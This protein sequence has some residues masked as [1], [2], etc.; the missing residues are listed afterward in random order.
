MGVPACGVNA[1]EALTSLACAAGG[2]EMGWGT[3]ETEVRGLSSRWTALPADMR[4][5]AKRELSPPHSDAPALELDGAG[6]M[7]WLVS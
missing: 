6:L 2:V 3:S 1:G 4:K 5:A 7:R